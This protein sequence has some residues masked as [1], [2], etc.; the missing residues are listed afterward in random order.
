M[1]A[2]ISTA[3][4]Y[5][6]HTED[7]LRQLISLSI[8]SVEI[9]LNTFSELED[10]YLR[11]LRRLADGSGVRVLAIH[12]FTSGMEPLFFFSRYD[13]RFQDGLELYK[14][15]FHAANLLG[16]EILVFHGNTRGIPIENDA[17]F[18]RFGRL[19]QAGKS[20]GVLVCQENVSRCTSHSPV[21][22][23]EMAAALPDARFVLDV[24][25][26][27]RS[28]ES[29]QSFIEALGRKIVHIHISDHTEQISCLPPGK[30]ILNTGRFLTDMQN[31]GFNGGIIVELY[32]ENFDTI[33]EIYEGYQH[34]LKAF[35]PRQIITKNVDR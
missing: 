25:Q 32:R 12:P 17:Y 21:F 10:T 8:Q 4:F 27:V 2:G 5:P 28:G 29:P 1:L 11:E 30:G 16:A 6:Q 3:C 7:T 19:I 14:R 15:F 31:T 26:A 9:F 18:E 13:R 20:F 33:V 23:R 35:P 22:L 34:V 24:K